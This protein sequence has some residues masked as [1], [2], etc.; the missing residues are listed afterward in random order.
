[1]FHRRAFTLVELLVVIAIIGLLSTIAVV[2]LSSARSK[3]RNAKK[4]GDV[5]QLTTALN[6]AYFDSATSKYPLGPGV[7]WACLSTVCTGWSGQFVGYQSL[8][9]TLIPTYL[10]SKP[11]YPE[12][13]TNPTGGG[14]IYNSAWGGDTGMPSGIVLLYVLEGVVSCPMGKLYGTPTVNTS[15]VIYFQE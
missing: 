14:Y 4:I 11:I 9:D 10:K 7:S 12:S 13:S 6:L 2:S 5:K 15:C 1:M 3:A 8:D